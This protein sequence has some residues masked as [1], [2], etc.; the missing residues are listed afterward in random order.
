MNYITTFDTLAD[1]LYALAAESTGYIVTVQTTTGTK[2][3]LHGQRDP[4]RDLLDY[5]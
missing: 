3:L 5:R 2:F 1:A 4:E